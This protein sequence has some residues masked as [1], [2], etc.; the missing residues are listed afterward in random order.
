MDTGQKKTNKTLSY[1]LKIIHDKPYNK[2]FPVEIVFAMS[3]L[4]LKNKL[5]TNTKKK[6]NES[7]RELFH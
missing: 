7:R 5:P 3:L 1:F 6:S 2:N 4:G